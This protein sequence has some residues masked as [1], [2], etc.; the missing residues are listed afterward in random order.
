MNP[1]LIEN[2]QFEVIQRKWQSQ[3]G[4]S[5][6][7]EIDVPV[8]G[9]SRKRRDGLLTNCSPILNRLRSPP[10]RPLLSPLFAASVKKKKT[11]EYQM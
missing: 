10:L 7:I 4:I 2:I 9:S 8:V 5:E 3:R 11:R 6:L 1:I